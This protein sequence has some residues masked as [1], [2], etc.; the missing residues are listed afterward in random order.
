MSDRFK[1]GG[2]AMIIASL[3]Y[4][5]D[6]TILLL[7]IGRLQPRYYHEKIVNIRYIHTPK[8]GIFIH[9]SAYG[10]V[11]LYCLLYPLF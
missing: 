10:I 5:K 8:T 7:H 9:D 4:K 6:A 1:S 11:N 3:Y 2:A